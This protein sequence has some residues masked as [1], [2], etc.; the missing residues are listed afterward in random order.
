MPLVLD[1]LTARY[2]SHMGG[3]S[4]LF[5]T[6]GDIMPGKGTYGLQQ[7]FVDSVSDVTLTAPLG[8]SPG[9]RRS[10]AGQDYMFVYNAGG[11]SAMVGWGVTVSETTG[12]SVTVSSLTNVSPLAGVVVNATMVTD[13]Y[14]W[15]C[16]HGPV[17]LDSYNGEDVTGGT[18][19][20][21]LAT[22]QNVCLGNDGSFSV[23]SVATDSAA[24]ACGFI[25]VGAT[26]GGS[27]AGFINSQI[28]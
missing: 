8:Y 16:T 24:G 7:V 19:T 2:S 13:S 20:G 25:A 28:F 9:M 15:I 17:P 1:S 3:V 21:T 22:G 4:P 5:L 26:T 10:E 11:A 23:C 27:G 6:F 18:A 14:C 12:Y